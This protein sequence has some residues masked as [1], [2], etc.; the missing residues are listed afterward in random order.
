M[1][2]RPAAPRAQDKLIFLLSLVPY[3]IDRER[4]TVDEAARH[5]GLPPKQIRDAVELLTVSGV[6][7]DTRQYLAGDL[8]DIDWGSFEEDDEIVLTHRVALDDSPRFSAREASAL[9]AGLQSLQRL[10]EFVDSDVIGGVMAKLARGASSVPGQLAVTESYSAAAVGII[11]SALAAG[12]SVEFDY[13]DATGATEA[14]LVDPLRLES[15]DQDWY[16]YGWCHLRE[17][18]RR[19]RLDRMTGLRESE[20][21]VVFREADVVVPTALFEPSESDRTVTVLVRSSVLALIDDY[22]VDVQRPAADAAVREDTDTEVTATLRLA[23]HHGLKRLVAAHPGLI[24]VL[25]PD[26]ARAAVS[27]WAAAGLAQY[28]PPVVG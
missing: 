6:P 25:G 22:V 26:D 18:T 19:F 11:R 8:F 20:A 16:L 2:K 1:A 14:R 21:E 12:H 15:Q 4:V 13:V 9:I 7:G 3:L 27:E 24:T 10:P 28:R 23:H 5:F 17:A